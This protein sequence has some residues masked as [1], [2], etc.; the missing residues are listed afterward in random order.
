M[1]TH[2]STLALK[3]PQTEEPGRLQSMGSLRVGHEWATSLSLFTFMHWR[4]KWRPTPVF[5][6]GESQGWRSLVGCCLWGR[7]VGHDWSDLAAAAATLGSDIPT[8]QPISWENHYSKSHAPQH[9]LQHYLQEP[10]HRPSKMSADRLKLKKRP[11]T[12]RQWAIIQQW[13]TGAAIMKSFHCSQRNG[14][15]RITY[16]V[17]PAR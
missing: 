4:R 16:W 17:K 15:W 2:S 3:I 8:S 1:A 5:L 14:C 6:P 11:G 7:T 9:P 13:K 12:Y 10:R